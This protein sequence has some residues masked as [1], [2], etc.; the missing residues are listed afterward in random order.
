[1]SKGALK[2]PSCSCKV[3]EGGS[4]AV[5][6]RTIKVGF[7]RMM[8]CFN[9]LLILLLHVRSGTGVNVLQE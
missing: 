5:E 3:L 9:S 6:E 4:L 2:C 8:L 7:G 1:M